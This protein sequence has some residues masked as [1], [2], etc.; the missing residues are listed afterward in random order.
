MRGARRSRNRR[1][2]TEPYYGTEYVT[3]DHLG[4]TRL[5]TNATG[6]VIRR[7]DYLPFGE[8]IPSGLYG[9]GSDYGGNS[10]PNL[11]VAGDETSR[12]FT[13][14]ERDSESGLDY[15][16]ARYFSAAQGRFT[17]A[18]WAAKAEPCV[19]YVSGTICYLCVRSRHRM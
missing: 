8:E 16:G 15:F 10:Y 1:T 5:L 18:D 17:S 14:K 3:G 11:G 12:K 4:S 2:Q 9:R 19:T 13:G 7:F 6:G